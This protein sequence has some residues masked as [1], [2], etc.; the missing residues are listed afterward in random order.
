MVYFN[1]TEGFHEK[2]D[3][4]FMPKIKR[5]NLLLDLCIIL[6]ELV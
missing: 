1:R 2:K 5:G 6:R 3:I 4:I